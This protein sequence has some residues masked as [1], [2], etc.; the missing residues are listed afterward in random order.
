[1]ELMSK[2]LGLAK[3]IEKKVILRRRDLHMHPEPG[4]T[5]FRT[6]SLVAKT[7]KELDYTVKLGDEVM[8]ASDMM[9]VPSKEKLELEMQ[10]AINQGAD[11]MLVEKMTGGKTGVVA[12]MFFSAD[13]P[14]VAM[15]FDMDSNDLLETKD[16]NHKPNIEGFASCNPKAMHGCGHDGHTSLGLAVAE[17]LANLKGQ[18]KG[19]IKL[20]FQPA[21]EGVRG[22]RAMVASGIVDDV[23]FMLGSHLGFKVKT[24]G[25]FLANLYGFLATSKYDVTYTGLAAHAGASP[26]SGTNALLAAANAALNL[27]AIS[28]HSEGASRINVGVLEAGSGRN[29][30]ADHAIMKIETRGASTKINEYMEKAMEKVL[31][32]S[33]LM[34]GVQMKIEKVGGAAGGNNSPSLVP[35][36]E[37]KAKETGLFKNILGS[38]NFG[39]SEDFSYFMER[40]QKNGGEAAYMLI[41]SNLAAGHHD[42]HF[43]FDENSL[44]KGIVVQT[45]I[46]TGLLLGEHKLLNKTII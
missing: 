36:L 40:V 19:T 4:W 13:G 14:T 17:L 31:E 43:D 7:L 10:R 37:D 5:E 23:D 33:A 12:T 30:I 28:R 39:G 20:I 34:Y 8:V 22:A 26:E 11:E 6:A 25:D 3:S 1:M 46:I 2:I 15:R 45:N 44:L 38:T 21:E 27:H 18:L 35:F 41:G 24:T 32:G 42:S 29:V 16:Q 9:G